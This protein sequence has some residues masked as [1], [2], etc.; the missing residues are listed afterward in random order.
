MSLNGLNSS[1]FSYSL[2][3]LQTVT[4]NGGQ[5]LPVVSGTNTTVINNGLDY[6]VNLNNDISINSI[7]ASSGSFGSLI[8]NNIKST[9]ASI[10]NFSGTN[11]TVTYLN[12]TTFTGTNAYINNA[13]INNLTISGVNIPN[14]TFS[15]A[16][17]GNLSLTGTIKSLNDNT[18]YLTYSIGTGTTN[19]TTNTTATNYFNNANTN[20]LMY[21]INNDNVISSNNGR[22]YFRPVGY[23]NTT[24]QGYIDNTGQL[25]IPSINI[26]SEISNN[27]SNSQNIT[28][29]TLQVNG[30]MTGSTIATTSTISAGG[31]LSTT[32]GKIQNGNGA[33]TTNSNDVFINSG[34]VGDTIYLRPKGLTATPADAQVYLGTNGNLTCTTGT[35]TAWNGYFNNGLNAPNA[36]VSVYGITSAYQVSS[37]NFTG[38]N[39]TITNLT[40]TN[41][42]GANIKGGS[43]NGNVSVT[44]PQKMY[45]Y[46][47]DGTTECLRIEPAFGTPALSWYNATYGSQLQFF[48]LCSSS[49]GAFTCNQNNATDY[50]YSPNALHDNFYTTRRDGLQTTTMS[51][52]NDTSFQSRPFLFQNKNQSAYVKAYGINGYNNGFVIGDTANERWFIYNK[53]NTSTLAINNNASDLITL[54][55][56]LMN[57]TPEVKVQNTLNVGAPNFGSNALINLGY[58]GTLGGSTLNTRM[59]YI[60]HD[61]SNLYIQNQQYNNANLQNSTIGGINLSPGNGIYP[62]IFYPSGQI[63]NSNKVEADAGATFNCLGTGS[64]GVYINKPNNNSINNYYNLVIQGNSYTSAI[65]MHSQV[66]GLVSNITLGRTNYPFSNNEAIT[67]RPY[68]LSSQDIYINITNDYQERNGKVYIGQNGTGGFRGSDAF[69]Q[70]WSN[71]SNAKLSGIYFQTDT[72]TYGVTAPA[73]YIDYT[74]Q[75]FMNP[76]SLRSGSNSMAG[77]AFSVNYGFKSLPQVGTIYTTSKGQGSYQTW[78]KGSVNNV[79][80]TVAGGTQKIQL[81]DGGSVN[82]SPFQTPAGARQY[83]FRA[84]WTGVYDVRWNLNLFCSAAT[85][86]FIYVYVNGAAVSTSIAYITAGNFSYCNGTKLIQVT[87]GQDVDMRILPDVNSVNIS[88]YSTIDAIYVG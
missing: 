9:G 8:V 25:V 20:P 80:Y 2:N 87:A 79:T 63:V 67:I 17:G 15:Q 85:N 58:T 43:F 1:I 4:S 77:S 49:G 70:N 39:A 61:S 53:A 37:P 22:I 54:T 45:F 48:M 32:S 10:Y 33:W 21:S 60:Y 59:G 46:Q 78:V 34:G 16:T 69:I 44:N 81:S 74:G 82:A 73:Q 65:T 66:S 31:V 50:T 11:G 76:Y 41:M 42:T 71:N 14:L 86:C 84:D 51:F 75:I 7:T 6:V 18:S 47:L 88:N 30:A 68:S 23:L 57:I 62:T 36:N 83:S 52:I 29:Q 38:A 40:V 3:G 24:S 13:T 72:S 26:N 19:Y 56:S 35:L 27:I 12:T 5:I 28:T 55:S 64:Y